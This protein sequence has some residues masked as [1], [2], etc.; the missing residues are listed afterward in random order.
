[1]RFHALDS[2]Y[3]APLLLVFFITL[4]LGCHK[5]V[6]KAS[7]VEKGSLGQK[8]PLTGKIYDVV[9]RSFI[10]EAQLMTALS[11]ADYLLLGEK[12]DNPQHHQLQAKV[13]ESLSTLGA[14]QL[15]MLTMGKAQR[16]K[17]A[18]SEDKFK[19]ASNWQSSGWPDYSIYRPLISAIYKRGLRPLPAHPARMDV[20]NHM[21]GSHSLPDQL[22]SDSIERLE[23][24]IERAH[25][26]HLNTSMVKMMTKAQ[27]YKDQFMAEEMS[28]QSG[29]GPVV[30]VAG[31][32]HI[33]TDYGIPNYLP[34]S[35]SLALLEVNRGKKDARAYETSP[36]QFVWFT[37]RVDNDDPCKKFEKQ[38]KKMK[39]RH[40]KTIE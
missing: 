24:D 6:H 15:E 1:M 34:R 28:K 11:G 20:F 31:N 16:L 22:T 14:V 26:G 33:R 32:G 12:H 9:T 27:S 8:H 39:H 5:H 13:I 18:D 23:A 19:E 3:R 29:R 35:T 40:Q 38:L 36:Y 2:I 21:K 30:L 17:I 10:T 4:M 25:C 7:E 37:Q